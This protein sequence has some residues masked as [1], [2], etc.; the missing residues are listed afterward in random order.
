V[1][2]AAVVA[3]A[4]VRHLAGDTTV[5]GDGATDGRDL[6]MQIIC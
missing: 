2:D 4:M 1:L 5:L 6:P 3:T